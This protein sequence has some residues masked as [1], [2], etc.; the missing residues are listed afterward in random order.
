MTD[1]D[2]RRSIAYSRVSTASQ[3]SSGLGLAAQRERAE[4]YA[5]AMGYVPVSSVTDEGVSGSVP[6]EERPGLGPALEALKDGRA[7]VLITASLSRL[8]RRVTDVLALADRAHREGWALAVLDLSLD[9]ASPTGRFTLTILAA[10][11]ELE[12]EQTRQRTRDA[13]QAAKARGQRLGRPV[14]D[15]TRKA[16]RRALAMRADGLTWRGVADALER[17]G[18]RTAKGKTHW[19]PASARNAARSVEQDDAAEAARQAAS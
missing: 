5:V 6:P 18:Y 14:S 16:G 15:A 12:R 4:S 17:D 2:T 8:G 10:V 13:L 19:H 7:D 11:A 9:T 3:A 1:R